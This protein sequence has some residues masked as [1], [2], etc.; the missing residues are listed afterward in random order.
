MKNHT[1]ETLGKTQIKQAAVI[2]SPIKHSKSPLIHQH[3]IHLYNLNATYSAMEISNA[4]ELK[5]C[6]EQLRSPEWVG[7]NVT[8]PHK[9]AVIPYLDS[10]SKEV[11]AIGACNTIVNKQGQLYGYNTDAEGFAYPLQGKPVA[12]AMVLGNGG[13]AR[14]VLYQ[15]CVMGVTTIRLVARDHSKSEAYCNALQQQFNVTIQPYSFKTVQQT[16]VQSVALIINTTSVGLSPNDTPFDFIKWVSNGQLFYDLI[17]NPA[18]TAM[19]ALCKQQGAEVINGAA[20]LAHQAALAF[21][22]FFNHPADTNIMLEVLE[23]HK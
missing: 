2:G 22:L 12:H 10:V 17:Y 5:Q 15:L 13:A 7:V 6:L 14:A 16:D 3:M 18:E 21:N 4:Q 11:Q 19:M 20:M 23:G 9:Q 8:I 1:S